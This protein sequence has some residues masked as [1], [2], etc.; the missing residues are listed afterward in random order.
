MSGAALGASS[1]PVGTTHTSVPK[2]CSS[3][4]PV[5]FTSIQLPLLGFFQILVVAQL[6]AII[7]YIFR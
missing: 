1:I 5:S 6:V 7:S 3:L 2:Y 4:I